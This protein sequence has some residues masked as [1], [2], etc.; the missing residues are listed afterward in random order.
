MSCELSAS[1]GTLPK[2]WKLYL[3]NS[4]FHVNMNNDEYRKNKPV[5]N[6]TPSVDS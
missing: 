6:R 2:R 4:S 1:D 3:T 5:E